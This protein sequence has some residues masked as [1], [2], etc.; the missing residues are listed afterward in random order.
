MLARK[1]INDE[2]DSLRSQGCC[3]SSE[4]DSADVTLYDVPLSGLNR[5]G[6]VPDTRESA[7]QPFLQHKSTISSSYTG[8]FHRKFKSCSSWVQ[9]LMYLCAIIS[10]SAGAYS[11]ACCLLYIKSTHDDRFLLSS[12][13]PEDWQKRR[14][15]RVAVRLESM[16]RDSRHACYT[17]LDVNVRTRH[18]VLTRNISFNPDGS[19][20]ASPVGGGHVSQQRSRVRTPKAIEPTASNTIYTSD[21]WQR[22]IDAAAGSGQKSAI[23][24]LLEPIVSITNTT[25]FGALY[26]ATWYNI[27]VH[28]INCTWFS[29]EEIRNHNER[30]HSAWSVNVPRQSINHDDGDVLAPHDDKVFLSHPVTHGVVDAVAHVVVDPVREHLTNLARAKANSQIMPDTHKSWTNWITGWMRDT[31]LQ[32]TPIVHLADKSNINIDAWQRSLDS[33]FESLEKKNRKHTNHGKSQTVD[34]LMSDHVQVK[35]IHLETKEVK[36]TSFFHHDAFCL[37]YYQLIN[38]GLVQCNDKQM[39]KS[40]VHHEF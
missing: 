11:V 23:W 40:T 24:H 32:S 2:H 9:K 8:R 12:Y 16:A 30:V 18:I 7:T 14:P 4:E 29:Q 13:T 28:S 1:R 17:S 20:Y 34:R 39:Y 33:V 10:F 36:K 21:T 38:E 31:P 27:P 37:Q 22:I 26:P 5:L 25:V 6:G 19:S 35:Y 3:W 15:Q